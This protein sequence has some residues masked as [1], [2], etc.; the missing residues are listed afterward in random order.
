MGT[1]KETN[2]TELDHIFDTIEEIRPF[3]NM[4]GGDIEFVKYDIE[5]KTVFVKM[6]GACAMCNMIDETLQNGLLELI[7]EKVPDIE[8]VINLPF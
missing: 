1:N 4:D 6:F 5:N 8:N 2:K 7:R 3:L